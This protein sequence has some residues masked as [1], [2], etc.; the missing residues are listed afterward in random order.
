MPFVDMN[1]RLPAKA[2]AFIAATP[3]AKGGFYG[4]VRVCARE[5]PLDWLAHKRDRF[6]L[7]IRREVH[8]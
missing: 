4:S 3:Q 7:G 5:A 1:W 8:R 6:A 2:G